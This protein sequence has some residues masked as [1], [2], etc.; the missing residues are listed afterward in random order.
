MGSL[1]LVFVRQTSLYKKRAP[2]FMPSN[3][4]NYQL[5]S[6]CIPIDWSGDLATPAGTARAEDP[7]LSV[8]REAAEAVPAESVQIG[9]EIN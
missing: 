2:F 8:A 7:G 1:L 3:L 6:L 5:D 9:T 4:L